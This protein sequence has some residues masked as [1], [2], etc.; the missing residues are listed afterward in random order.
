MKWIRPIVATASLLVSISPGMVLAQETSEYSLGTID[1]LLSACTYQGTD[2]AEVEYQFGSCIGFIRGV[3]VTMES[4]SL[5]QG[6]AFSCP[7]NG[8]TENGELREAVV[9]ELRRSRDTQVN[10]SVFPVMDALRHLYPCRAHPDSAP[11][12]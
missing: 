6:H 10:I 4:I 7:P 3:R 2:R 8:V 12:H 5:A 11:G 1:G 9:A